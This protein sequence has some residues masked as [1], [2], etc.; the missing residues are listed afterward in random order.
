MCTVQQV[1]DLRSISLLSGPGT[2]ILGPD[3]RPHC[4]EWTLPRA[5]DE[6]QQAQGCGPENPQI[7]EQVQGTSWVLTV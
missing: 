2:A 6:A 1:S 5:W 4:T 7:P 3:V